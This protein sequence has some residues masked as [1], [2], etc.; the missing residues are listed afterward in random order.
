[1][2]QKTETK[3]RSCPTCKTQNPDKGRSFD[4]RAYRCKSC[5]LIWTE[6]PQ[7]REK[8]ISDQR[9]GFQFSDSRGVGHIS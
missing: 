3:S 7:G 1:M 2:S 5:K 4:G 9:Q 6:G 8:R